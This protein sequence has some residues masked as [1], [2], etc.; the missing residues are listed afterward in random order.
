MQA[1]GNLRNARDCTCAHRKDL[2]GKFPALPGIRSAEAKQLWVHV[3]VP[4]IVGT[5]EAKQLWIPRG[6]T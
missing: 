2:V 5:A 1:K 3:G 4:I 6:C